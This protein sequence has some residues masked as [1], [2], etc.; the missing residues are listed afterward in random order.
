VRYFAAFAPCFVFRIDACHDCRKRL[1]VRPRTPIDLLS[2]S[3]GSE[4]SEAD[5]VRAKAR[6]N[7]AAVLHSL[8]ASDSDS[9]TSDS[10]EFAIQRTKPTLPQT[11]QSQLERST[12]LGWSG[13]EVEAL[14]A[15]V[16]RFGTG[17]WKKILEFYRSEFDPKRTAEK[18]KVLDN[19]SLPS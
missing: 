14:K 10:P 1:H 16:A 13:D 8:A 18:L 5:R 11:P 4:G 2:T 9:D 7:A 6:R 19:G 3:E 17:K 12:R 15:G